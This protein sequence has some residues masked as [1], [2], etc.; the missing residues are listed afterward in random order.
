MTNV[1]VPVGV[2]PDDVVT[3]ALSEID[4]APM[5]TGADARVEIP[6][7]AGLTVVL[8]LASLQAPD[9]AALLPSP[10]YVAMKR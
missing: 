9:T 4:P 3:V 5:V 8:S 7:A 1:T 2:T 10:L 6:D